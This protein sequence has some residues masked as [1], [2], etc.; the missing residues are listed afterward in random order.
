MHIPR[1]IPS[2]LVIVA[3][4]LALLL[5]GGGATALAG[6]HWQAR[7][8]DYPGSTLVSEH[9]RVGVRD[10]LFVRQDASYRTDDTFPVVYTWYSTGFGLGPESRAHGPCILMERTRVRLLL[11][12]QH[13]SVMVCDT[14]HERR[15]YVERTLSLR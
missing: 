11:F 9:A 2:P 5:L 3:V 12:N 6:L 15:V 1:R 8:A 7:V 14:R 10:G 13:M 4:V